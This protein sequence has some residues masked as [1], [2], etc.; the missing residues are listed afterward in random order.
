VLVLKEPK[1]SEGTDCRVSCDSEGEL[2]R[3]RGHAPF[4]IVFGYGR[5]GVRQDPMVAVRLGPAVQMQLARTV[6]TL[7]W[8][9]QLLN[10]ER[11]RDVRNAL[12]GNRLSSGQPPDPKPRPGPVVDVRVDFRGPFSAVIEDG[13]RCLFTDE[14]I[15]KG[16]GVYLWT[17]RVEGEERPWYVGQT[18]RGFGQRMGEHLASFLSGEY[19]APDSKSLSRGENRRAVPHIDDDWPERLPAFL[20]NY[21]ILMPNV[22]QV[23]RS[24]HFYVASLKGHDAH[25][26]NRVEG[27]IGR[28]Y[29]AHPLEHLRDFFS[30]NLRVPAA[31]AYDYPIRLELSSET[32]LAGLPAEMLE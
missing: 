8:D 4:D 30:P 6:G 32:P 31:I 5:A 19:S 25:T 23:I 17:I 13:C 18:R 1:G 22:I 26:Y 14:E 15:A 20:E 3:L 2:F 7:G 27:A 9:L 21:E 10:K 11:F 16:V 24:L 28:Y 12:Y 29:K